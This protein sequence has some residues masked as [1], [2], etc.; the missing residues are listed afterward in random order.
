MTGLDFGVF[1]GSAAGSW[2][3]TCG[4]G[5]LGTEP[6]IMIRCPTLAGLVLTEDFCFGIPNILFCTFAF[7]HN[8]SVL[9][10]CHS[11]WEEDE[12]AAVMWRGHP[13]FMK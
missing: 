11:D 10:V 9:I 8:E 4:R 3:P 12:A 13:G 1:G 5:A 2:F 6:W 7:V